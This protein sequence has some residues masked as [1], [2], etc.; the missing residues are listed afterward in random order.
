M[1]QAQKKYIV[2]WTHAQARHFAQTMEWKRSEWV[3]VNP[4]SPERALAG[5]YNVLIYEVRAP[6]YR[7]NQVEQTNM[8][9]MWEY[10]RPVIESQRARLNV[11]NI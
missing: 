3:Y 2:A 1:I 6:R 5:I 8:D 4:Q 10:L 9:R 7:P 11:V